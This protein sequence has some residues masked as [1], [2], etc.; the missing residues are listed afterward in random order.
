VAQGKIQKPP[1]TKQ[2]LE[3]IADNLLQRSGLYGVLPTPLDVLSEHAGLTCIKDLPEKESFIKTLSEKGKR[4]F[5][6]AL[7]TLRGIADLRDDVIYLPKGQTDVRERFAHSHEISHHEI[8]W[9]NT[10]DPYFDTKFT[11][12][13]E[14][15]NGFER[16]ANYLGAELIYQGDH[17]RR[18]ALDYK[19]NMGT[20]IML[21]EEHGASYHATIWKLVEVQD[22]K[23]C[24]AQ[25][26]PVKHGPQEGC[27]RLEK[28]IGSENFNK[29]ITAV[30]LPNIISAEHDWYSAVSLGEMPR[31]TI[32]LL[33]DG[34]SRIFEW[35]AWFNQY[36]LFVMLRDKPRLHKIGKII[37]PNKELVMT[38]TSFFGL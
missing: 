7:Q 24:V 25:Y 8:P 19:A 5:E 14:I 9:H 17:F 30:D 2:D 6:S 35:S 36:T 21:A 12:S 10:D 4:Q 37:K 15:Q 38:K 31:G 26:Y 34:H 16:E 23:I 32:N 11:L 29:K 1:D 3:E 33:V 28:T 18:M 22:E 20:A 27:F 13:A